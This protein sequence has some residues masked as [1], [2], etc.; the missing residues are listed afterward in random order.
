MSVA[1]DETE[2][3]LYLDD[4]DPDPEP[5]SVIEETPVADDLPVKE[6]E[7]DASPESTDEETPVELEADLAAELVA[8]GVHSF[9]W[10]LKGMDCPDCAMKAV[11]AVNRQDGVIDCQISPTD[12]LVKV[13]LDLA[14]AN[15]SRTSGILSS[16]GHDPDVPWYQLKGVSQIGLQDRHG[17]ERGALKRLLLTAPGVLHTRFENDRLLLQHAELSVDMRIE[18]EQALERMTGRPPVLIEIQPDRLESDQLRLLGAAITVPLLLL[19]LLLQSSGAPALLVTVVGTLGVVLGGWRMFL[20]ALASL[21]NMVLGFQVLTSLAVIGAVAMGHWPEALTVV[22]LEALSGHLESSALVQAR[23][24]MQGG[25]DR[26]PRLARVLPST[27]GKKLSMVT[28][29]PPAKKNSLIMAKSEPAASCDTEEIPIELVNVGDHVEVRSGALVPVDGEIIEGIGSLD[30]APLTGESVPVRVVVGDEIEAGLVLRRGPILI[31]TTAV[32]DQTRLSGLIDKVHTYRDATPRLQGAIELFTLVW[33]PLVLVG[34]ALAALFMGD[35]MV[36]LL[37]WVV[38]CPCALLLAAPVPHAMAL[39]NAAHN[40]LVARGGDVLERVARI[41]LALLD[42]TGTLTRGEPKLVEVI[43]APGQRRE[44]ILRLAAGIEERSN[45]AYA[46]TVR[47]RASEESLK[48]MKVTEISDEQAGVSGLLKAKKVRFG[49]DDWIV[50]LGIEVPEVLE[51]AALE[52]R[53]AGRGL[54]LLTEDDAAI[55]IFVFEHDDIRGGADDMIAELK[56]QGIA[57]ELLSGDS[58][59]AVEALGE[60]LGI[61]AD[62]C[63][64]EIS[65]EGKAIWVQR[66]SHARRTLMAGDGF[67]DAAAL[68]A[69]DVG[70]AVGSGEQV[71]LDAADVLIPS[72]DPRQLSSLVRLSRRTRLIVLANILISFLVTLTLVVSVLDGWHAS[73]ALGVF[74]H[75]AS[76]LLVLLNGIWL[77]D[78]GMSRLGLLAGLFVNL[79]NDARE[80]FGKLRHQKLAFIR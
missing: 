16:L 13:E 18:M 10:L 74:V 66:R 32:G 77:A 79:W 61:E 25:L 26:L 59:S 29:S 55:A 60:R 69:A 9:G 41:D 53:V 33:V 36:M 3:W 19:L 50:S 44:R 57:V 58:Q 49:R 14:A 15:L 12:G 48:P 78:A 47:Q 27:S 51:A 71:N 8:D 67:N 4:P 1:G 56:R 80:A 24:A 11:R 76:A 5:E 73:L 21:R 75:E 35:V 40:G 70:V 28:N 31:R 17:V 23:S 34:G 42:K 7:A 37:L 64:G 20:E 52:A 63:R 43:S 6:E 46:A 38:A 30:R 22:L 68:A 45:H 62:S 72:E 65:P 39:T 2:P 54:S